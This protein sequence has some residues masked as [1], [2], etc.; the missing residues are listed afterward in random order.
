MDFFNNLFTRP[1]YKKK[2]KGLDKG[3]EIENNFWF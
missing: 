2:G 3:I 1:I